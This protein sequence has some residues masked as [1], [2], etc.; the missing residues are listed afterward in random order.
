MLNASTNAVD[1]SLQPVDV[2]ISMGRVDQGSL[3]QEIQKKSYR[4]SSHSFQN[5]DYMPDGIARD[6]SSWSVHE[7]RVC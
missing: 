6:M 2:D 5:G 4:V 7:H 3:R 1:V